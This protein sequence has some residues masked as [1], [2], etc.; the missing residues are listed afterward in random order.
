VASFG[1]GP[2]RVAVP[3]EDGKER[4]GCKKYAVILVTVEVFNTVI[5]QI[6]VFIDAKSGTVAG[7]H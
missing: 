3:F 4:L 1:S 2:G 6:A 5:V 7:S